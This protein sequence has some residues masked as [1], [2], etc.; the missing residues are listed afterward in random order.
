MMRAFLFDIDGTLVDSAAAIEDAWQRVAT[1][2]GVSAEQILQSCHG[3]RDTEV[4]EEFFEQSVWGRVLGRINALDMGAL[5]AVS[6]ARGARDLLG[7][8]ADDQWAAV[9]SG[10]RELMTAR[11]RTAGLPVPNVLV[12]AEDVRNGKPDPEGFLLAAHSLGVEPSDCVVVEDSPAGVAAGRAA[13]A[14]VVGVTTTHSADDL[15]AADLVVADLT[16]L[17]DALGRGPTNGEGS[18]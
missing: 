7:T 1:E 8:L 17:L 13:G 16:R 6:A 3:R 9:T 10:P 14:I 12:T 11:L 15:R 2:F 18:P 4:V 5:A